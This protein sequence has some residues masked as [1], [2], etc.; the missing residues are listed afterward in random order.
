MTSDRL[1][2]DRPFS[3]SLVQPLIGWGFTHMITSQSSSSLGKAFLMIT[4]SPLLPVL[5]F[6]S[7]VAAG[8]FLIDLLLPRLAEDSLPLLLVEEEELPLSAF[9]LVFSQKS[10]VL[11]NTGS[12][13]Q[14]L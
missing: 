13:L 7:P 6:F 3:L 10:V 14:P 11:K 1:S 12:H 9:I 8:L 4:F 2:S 5:E